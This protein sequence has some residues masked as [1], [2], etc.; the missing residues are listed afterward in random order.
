[1]AILVFRDRA[2]EDI[3]YGRSSKPARQRLAANLHAKARIKLARLHASESLKD[4]ADLPGNRLEKLAGNRSGQHS[5]RLNDQY[6]ICFRWSNQ[7]AFDVE[8]VDYH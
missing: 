8:I 4:L 2:T 7:G 5:I 1:M 3:N 6:K